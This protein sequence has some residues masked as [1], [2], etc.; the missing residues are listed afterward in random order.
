MQVKTQRDQEAETAARA[1]K[2]LDS[3]RRSAADAITAWNRRLGAAVDFH[4]PQDAAPVRPP[5]LRQ[6]LRYPH[7]DPRT[8]E[9]HRQPYVHRHAQGDGRR[10]SGRGLRWLV[11]TLPEGASNENEIGARRGGRLNVAAPATVA[12]PTASEALDRIEMPDDA[13]RKALRNALGRGRAHRIG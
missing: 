6:G 7:R 9:A 4:Q 8:R 3:N 5:G 2:D 11:L 10:R 13:S 12:Q 1:V